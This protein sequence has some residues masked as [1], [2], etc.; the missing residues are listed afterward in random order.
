MK[1]SAA[2]VVQQ[3]QLAIID[4]ENAAPKNTEADRSRPRGLFPK[5]QGEYHDY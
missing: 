4:S 5:E 1:E 3:N 2:L